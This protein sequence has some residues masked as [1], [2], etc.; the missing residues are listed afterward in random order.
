EVGR[1][2]VRQ[3][4][5]LRLFSRLRQDRDRQRQR[6]VARPA[7]HTEAHAFELHSTKQRPRRLPA[8][9]RVLREPEQALTQEEELR[10][11]ERDAAP[12]HRQTKVAR[13]E[14]TV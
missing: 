13:Q 9:E 12:P 7:T 10:A 8:V 3:R 4:E 11:L 1:V 14:Q 6:R 5:L 2:D